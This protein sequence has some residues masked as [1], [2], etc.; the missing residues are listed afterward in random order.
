M[1][2]LPTLKP[3]DQVEIIAPASRCSVESLHA[4]ESLLTSWGLDCVIDKAMFG[5]DVLCAN[6]DTMRFMLLNQALKNP[7][8]KAIVCARGGYGSLRLISKLSQC[9]PTHPP[10]IFVGMSD[11]TALHLFLNQQW[12]WPTIHA[13]LT[14]DKV[15]TASIL[16]IKALLF[17]EK[18]SI[19]LSG[20]ALNPHA[21]QNICLNSTVIGGNLSI[22]QTSVGTLW[23]LNGKN[24][25]VFLEEIGERGYRV[26]RMLAHL[27]QTGMF[28]NA[29]AILLGDFIEGPEP[30]GTS[31]IAPILQRF[32]DSSPIPVVQIQGLGHGHTNFPLPL[33][34][35]ATLQLGNTITLTCQT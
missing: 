33:G 6:S 28:Q 35:Q 12:Q 24:K 11:I 19:T 2:P 23:H 9:A 1:Y 25:V 8:T 32:A 4:L 31:L 5:D 34:T 26:D 17:K 20:K 22:V 29:A 10:K 30:N 27:E 15:S 21:K 16:A 3:G 7:D 13:S 14:Q 18:N